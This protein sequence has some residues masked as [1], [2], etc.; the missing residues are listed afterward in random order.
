M[1]KCLAEFPCENV[2]PWNFVWGEFN[3]NTSKWSVQISYFFFLILS[4]K[5]VYFRNLSISSRLSCLLA[6]DY[7][8]YDCISIIFGYN[9]HS[10]ISY[11]IYFGLF[12]FFLMSLTED[13]SFFLIFSKN[14][15]SLSLSFCGMLFGFHICIFL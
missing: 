4:W 14:H 12:L 13:F 3:F 9:F 2:W 8:N 6:H 7:A 11:F 10:F 1:F 15:L 5:T